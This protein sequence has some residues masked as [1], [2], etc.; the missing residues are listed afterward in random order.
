MSKRRNI[1]YRYLKTKMALSETIQAILDINKKRQF[2]KKD[3]R[4]K[5]ALNEE[6]R[7]LNAV[8]ENQALSLR[9][10]EQRMER[11]EAA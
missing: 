2:F 8:A 11:E 10:Y 7:V 5:Q 1:K 6:L 3:E 9:T 4:R